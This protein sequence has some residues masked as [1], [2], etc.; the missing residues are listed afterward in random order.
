M[1]D[2]ANFQTSPTLLGRLRRSP[3][4]ESAWRDFVGRYK[5]LILRWCGQWGL[6]SADAEDLTQNVLL[7]LSRQM[8]RFEYDPMKRFRSWLKT[9]SYRAWC[10]FLEQRRRQEDAASGDSQVM[11]LL[12]S[13]EAYDDLLKKLEDEWQLELL[14]EAM[15]LVQQ[16]AQPQ[17]WEVFRLLTQE[18]LSGA[19]VAQ[20]L[21]MKVGAVWVARSRVQKMIQEEIRALEDLDQVI[22]S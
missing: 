12:N 11:E 18:K 17:T 20:K 19:E 15:R 4:D 6:Q 13:Q 3:N 21:D 5:K 9:V 22:Q 16:R 10:D 2:E 1:V 14:E 7:Q 8:D